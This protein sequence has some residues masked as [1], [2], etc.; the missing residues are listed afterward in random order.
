MGNQSCV[1][2]GVSGVRYVQLVNYLN[3]PLQV[4][5]LAVY[6]SLGDRLT[7]TCTSTSSVSGGQACGQAICGNL[8]VRDVAASFVSASGNVDESL[9]L[10]FPAERTVSKIVLFNTIQGVE[11]IVRSKLQLL[12]SN[13]KLLQELIVSVKDGIQTFALSVDPLA[14]GLCVSPRP[15]TVYSDCLSLLSCLAESTL[16]RG[17]NAL[18][19]LC[20]LPLV[21]QHWSAIMQLMET[22][23]LVRSPMSL[24]MAMRFTQ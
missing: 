14:L 12:D 7:A 21:A 4:S 13:K 22:P 3:K 16:P 15:P 6:G 8:A 10:M 23:S 17:P 24:T 2:T 18:K 1:A 9:V 20:K 5:Q 19:A 11:N